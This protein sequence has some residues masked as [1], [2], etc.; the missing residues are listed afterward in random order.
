MDF[1]YIL[2][3]SRGYTVVAILILKKLLSVRL[4]KRKIKRLCFSFTF[5]LSNI[6]SF[7]MYIWG[8]DLH[9]SSLRKTSFNISCSVGLQGT[10]SLNFRL[11]EEV[12]IYPLLLKDNLSGYIILGWWS[13]S[14]NTFLFHS[15]L[16]LFTRFLKRSPV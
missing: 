12:F 8:F 4:I 2:T 11:S 10:N 7:F 14:F 13:F 9:H 5:P 15:T 3:T 16:S 6:L 1:T